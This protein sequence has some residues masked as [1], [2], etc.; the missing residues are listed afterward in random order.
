M[1]EHEAKQAAEQCQ[2]GAFHNGCRKQFALAC[3]HR[4]HDGQIV[5]TLF[6]RVVQRNENA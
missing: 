4:A 3:A 6:Q 1:T 2:C 5:L